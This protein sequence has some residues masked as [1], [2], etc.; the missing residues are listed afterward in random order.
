MKTLLTWFSLLWFAT[1]LTAATASREETI[2]LFENRKLMVAVPEGLGCVTEKDDA[3]IVVVRISDP[4]QK[5]S[6]EVRFLPDPEERFTQAR[7]RKELIH[8][9]FSDYVPSST[10]KGIQFEE[11]DPKVGKGTYC[12]FTDASLVGKTNLPPGEFL[13]LTAG[14]KAWPGVVAVFRIFS[15]ETTSPEYQSVLRML[16]ESVEERAV[17]LK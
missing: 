7:A 13:H 3:G 4:K 12:V 1:C 16:R 17:P 15:N 6:G 9:M 2:F 14:L 10:E 8:E 5:V 11:L